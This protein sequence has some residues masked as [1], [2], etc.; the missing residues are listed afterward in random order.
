MS[1]KEK[2]IGLLLNMSHYVCSNC[3]TPH[4]LFGSP[5]KFERAANDLEL[6]VLG[7]FRS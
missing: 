5:E 6:D 2:I 3:Q 1:S 4:Q 7:E